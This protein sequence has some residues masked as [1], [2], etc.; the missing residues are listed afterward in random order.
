M[1]LAVTVRQ[2]AIE[3]RMLRDELADYASTRQKSAI[4]SSPL[5]GRRENHESIVIFVWT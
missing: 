5:R 3:D 1:Y 2:T 4:G